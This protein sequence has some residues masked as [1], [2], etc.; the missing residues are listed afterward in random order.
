MRQ[1]F[2]ILVAAAA[3]A[4][5]CAPAAA[6][7]SF[8]LAAHVG[9]TDI[10]RVQRSGGPWW[11][12]VDDSATSLGL[13]LGYEFSRILGLRLGYERA[14]DLRATNLCPP[15][16][17]C[18]AIAIKEQQDFTTWQLALVPRLPLAGQWSLF[19]LLG[20]M[21][22]KLSRDDLLPAGSETSL[23]YGV[24]LGRR[25]GMAEF[26]VEYQATDDVYRGL[27]FNAGVRF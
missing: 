14:R 12:D 13:S 2:A 1:Y 9:S 3:L 17:A 5:T 11:T 18:P 15:G 8:S 4:V 23:V 21:D 6:Q 22:M 16:A 19:G 26:G 20:V 27:R 10:E 25:L 7:G 24:G